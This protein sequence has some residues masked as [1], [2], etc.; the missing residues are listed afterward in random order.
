VG[1]Q[2]A[3]TKIQIYRPSDRVLQRISAVRSFS[4][5][6]YKRDPSE[7]QAQSPHA[8]SSRD[9][10]AAMPNPLR[11]SPPILYLSLLRMPATGGGSGH[12]GDGRRWQRPCRRRTGSDGSSHAGDGAATPTTNGQRRAGGQGDGRHLLFHVPPTSS[13][14]P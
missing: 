8:S 13:V 1:G 7:K 11:V 6:A 4:P 2:E 3:S 12:A 9:S 14:L 5:R 10:S